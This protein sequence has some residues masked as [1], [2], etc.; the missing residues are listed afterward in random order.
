MFI[1]QRFGNLTSHQGQFR[2]ENKF[3][4]SDQDQP[5]LSVKQEN[6]QQI[7]L[8]ENNHTMQACIKHFICKITSSK[9]V[10]VSLKVTFKEQ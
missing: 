3:C 10:N 9:C 2:K 7:D 1:R 5:F 6:Y 4:Y 8:N